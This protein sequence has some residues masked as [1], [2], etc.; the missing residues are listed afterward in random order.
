MNSQTSSK[1]RYIEELIKIKKSHKISK[2]KINLLN[3]IS[4][5]IFEEKYGLDQK[6]TYDDLTE[7]LRKKEQ[8]KLS[9][10]SKQMSLYYYSGKELNNN[11]INEL[12]GYL[13]KIIT[14]M[15]Y[16]SE[17]IDKKNSKL[18]LKR[19]KKESNNNLTNPEYLNALQKNPKTYTNLKKSFESINEKMLKLNKLIKERY[20]QGDKRIKREIE[21]TINNYK[22]QISKISQKTENPF[23]RC[24]LQQKILE[25]SYKKIELLR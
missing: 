25:E 15:D 23:E 20:T 14:T 3:N 9:I 6:L 13:I 16:D 1:N 4:K 17:E 19:I 8:E 22:E 12:I 10:F 18:G 24:I 5:K 21:E 2:E 7:K 11:R